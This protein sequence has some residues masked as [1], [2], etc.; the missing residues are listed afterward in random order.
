MTIEPTSNERSAMTRLPA[1]QTGLALI[2]L[3]LLAGT[4]VGAASADEPLQ[5]ATRVD[6]PESIEAMA[7]AYDGPLRFEI[8]RDGSRVGQH[9]V[10]FVQ[11]GAQL[12]VEAETEIAVRFLGLTVYRFSYLSE[13]LWDDE[14]LRAL[15]ARTDDDGEVSTVDVERQAEGFTIRNDEGETRAEAP[16]FPTDHWHSQV[17]GQEQVLNTITGRLNS[18]DIAF[19][20][21]ERVQTGSGE[22]PAR[23]YRYDGDLQASVWYDEEGRWVRLRFLDQR[24]EAIDYVCVEC[25]T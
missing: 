7:A 13:S 24:G 15:Q 6:T 10:R 12:R 3:A 17:L 16:L 1:A 8:R 18:V 22:R 11:D 20:E 21:E 23:H 25:G 19:E 4:A 2:S 14:G 9:E 5:L